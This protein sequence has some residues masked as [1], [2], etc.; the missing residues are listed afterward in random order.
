M[1]QL[2]QRLDVRQEEQKVKL[3]E[4]EQLQLQ[5]AFGSSQEEQQVELKELEHLQ[6]QLTELQHLKETELKEQLELTAAEAV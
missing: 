2:Q 3:Q 5:L 4:L 1:Q 6:L